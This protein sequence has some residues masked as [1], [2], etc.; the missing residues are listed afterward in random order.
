MTEVEFES[1][2]M[3]EPPKQEQYAGLNCV[4]C[5]DL[6]S[7]K[8][9]SCILCTVSFH[10]KCIERWLKYSPKRTC[11]QCGTEQMQLFRNRPTE[12]ACAQITETNVVTCTYCK[13]G[14]SPIVLPDGKSLTLAIE[15]LAYHYQ[16][17]AFYSQKQYE[18]F[19]ACSQFLMELEKDET[20]QK[21]VVLGI[22]VE[23][24]TKR[25]VFKLRYK[26]L[27]TPVKLGISFRRH[28]TVGTCF[29]VSCQIVSA[30]VSV[31][32]PLRFGITIQDSGG[33]FSKIINITNAVGSFKIEKLMYKLPEELR[34]WTVLF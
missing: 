27:D 31:V 21:S 30:P 26:K 25:F 18:K 12:V 6:L 14:L 5:Q 1:Y 13:T 11:P 10:G 34:V 16:N 33:F 15:I 2:R 4:I 7:G 29:L 19:S 28:K 20:K 3:Y 8:V 32:Y 24:V 23:T 9:Q 22:P 17:C